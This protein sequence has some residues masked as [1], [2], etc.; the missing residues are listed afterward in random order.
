MILTGIL[1]LAVSPLLAAPSSG[2]QSANQGANDSDAMAQDCDLSVSGSP[3]IPVDSWIY[4]A[5]LRLYSLGFLDHVYLGLRP[6]T[7]AS[8]SHMLEDTEAKFEDAAGGPV[9]DEARRDLRCA[10]TRIASAIPKLPVWRMG[11][12]CASSQ[13]IP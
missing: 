6:W 1:F 11:A 8:L 10:D 4:P 7:R 5:V 3:Y 9:T 13:L 2:E 12:R